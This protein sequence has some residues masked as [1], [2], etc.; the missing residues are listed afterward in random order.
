MQTYTATSYIRTLDSG[1]NRPILI[2]A[3]KIDGEERVEIVLK[4]YDTKAARKRNGTREMVAAHLALKLD[5]PCITPCIVEI[6]Q[7]F[8]DIIADKEVRA[9]LVGCLG[10]QFGSLYIPNLI[11]VTR[12]SHLDSAYADEG[13]R[14][15]HF[16]ALIQ[17]TDRT[18]RAGG[19]ANLF[20]SDGRFL[21]LDH[22]KAFSFLDLLFDLGTYSWQLDDNMVAL[23]KDHVLFGYLQQNKGQDFSVLVGWLDA[24]SVAFWLAT[25]ERLPDA[26]C[27]ADDLK[28]IENHIA[29]VRD[30]QS[31][32]CQQ[33]Q[34][35][36]A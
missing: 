32:F 8:V 17:N 35:L 22:E 12:N 34:T 20:L 25:N 16:D 6:N 9:R 21:L 31:D 36:V 11:S 30:H 1:A 14:L 28:K 15:F 24:L 2:E 5:L 3:K 29:A 19:K 13:Q 18:L 23:M 4:P 10:L 7:S 33:L 27:D 26:L